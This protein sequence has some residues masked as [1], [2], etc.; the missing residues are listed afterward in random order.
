MYAAQ[1]FA[2]TDAAMTGE[3]MARRYLDH[4]QAIA[5]MASS[6]EGPYVVAIGQAGLRRR[7]LAYP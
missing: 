1:V 2:L 5:R 7:R 3:A 4:Q 6:A